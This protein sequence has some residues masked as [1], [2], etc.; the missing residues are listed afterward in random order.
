MSL[1][2]FLI[3]FLFLAGAMVTVILVANSVM[4]KKEV[5]QMKDLVSGKASQSTA[6]GGPSLIKTERPTAREMFSQI[7]LG[8]SLNQKVRD[9]IEQA[10]LDWDPARTIYLSLILAV[11]GF[12]IFWY[13]IPR[14]QPIAIV[15]VIIGGG[16]PAFI[17]W[18][19]RSK[20]LYAF[21][22]QFPDALEYL[23][24][25][26]RTGHA[27]TVALEMVH[28]EYDDPL[29]EEFRRA[30]E[31][32]NLGLP[33]EVALERLG[34]R[35]PL[36]DVRFFVSAVALQKRTGGNL[37]ALLDNLSY[38]IRERFKLRGKIRA[39]SAHGRISGLVLSMIPIVTAI[40]MFLTNPEY[41]LFFFDDPDGK[42]LMAVMIIMQFLGF[43]SIKKL[44]DI[45]P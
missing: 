19:K 33:L 16:I 40:L 17:I 42:M 22:E 44:T 34:T 10:G 13:L 32:Q 30:F 4:R 41:V 26:M 28:K 6:T 8:K 36:L 37:A 39:I 20:R 1:T 25:A 12:N 18:R 35:V 45:N 24:R 2:F 31:E 29:G 15:G 21:E 11:I 23:G 7:F 3:F 43:V 9:W 14:G 27:F 38:L 5:D